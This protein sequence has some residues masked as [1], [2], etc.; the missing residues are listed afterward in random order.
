MTRILIIVGFTMLGLGAGMLN[1][2]AWA[3][4]PALGS[5]ASIVTGS[6]I[7]MIAMQGP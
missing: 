5:V 7:L 2:L 1:I 6:F 4:S 3:Q